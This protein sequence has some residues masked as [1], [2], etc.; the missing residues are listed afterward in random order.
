MCKK[1]N[2]ISPSRGI[3]A[4]VLAGSNVMLVIPL[5]QVNG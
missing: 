2:F 1:P 3:Q 4:V 5:V